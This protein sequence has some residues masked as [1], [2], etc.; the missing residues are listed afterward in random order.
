MKSPARL[1]V[2]L[3]A[4]LGLLAAACGDS[5]PADTSAAAAEP[6]IDGLAA[7]DDVRLTEVLDVETGEATTIADTVTGDRPVLL[8][9]W[10][11]H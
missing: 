10:A 8:W 4:A 6:D 1:L 3:L 11:P 5:S 7:S 9:F 2:A